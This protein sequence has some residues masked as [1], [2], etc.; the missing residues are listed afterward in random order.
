MS[1]FKVYSCQTLKYKKYFQIKASGILD[2]WTF[3]GYL[4][5]SITR[6]DINQQVSIPIQTSIFL[7][8]SLLFNFLIAKPLPL[9]LHLDPSL[10][11]QL[12]Q[13]TLHL[14]ILKW[15]LILDSI[16]MFLVLTHIRY[17]LFSPN[18]AVKSSSQLH[19]ICTFSYLRHSKN[20]LLFV[21]PL[22]KFVNSFIDY[23][24]K[25]L[26]YSKLN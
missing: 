6:T 5:F 14:Y 21:A 24:L 13:P 17:F 8:N 9:T 22:S 7:S 20:P 10:L 4:G 12:S 3:P 25:F 18:L 2:D 23:N 16:P 26:L 11:F 19:S 15:N 1:F